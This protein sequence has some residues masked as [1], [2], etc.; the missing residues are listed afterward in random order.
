MIYLA[1]PY[2]HPE[3]AV[4]ELRYRAVCRCAGRL[5]REGHIVF[6]PIAHSHSIAKECGI[7]PDLGFWM[8]Q[9]EPM[10]GLAS[11]LWIYTIPGWKTSLGVLEELRIAYD[12]FDLPIKKCPPDECERAILQGEE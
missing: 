10:I 5:M 3:P 9:D 11:E 8:R 1:S 4:M 6:S 7:P 12:M 2:S